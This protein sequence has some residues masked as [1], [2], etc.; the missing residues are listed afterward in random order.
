MITIKNLTVSFPGFS[1]ND[2]DLAIEKGE[3]FILL[4]P[5]GAGKTILLEAIAG[6]VPIQDGHI[7]IAGA[8]VT[9]FPPEKRGVGIVYQDYAL[10]PHLSV[11]DNICYGLHFHEI[12]K[13]ESE[14]RLERLI[15]QLG[16][17]SLTHRSTEH[18]SGGEKQRVALARSLMVAPTVLLLD[19]PLSALD[20]HFRQDLRR[21]LKRLQ[22]ETKI[23][24]FMVTHDLVDVMCLA[25]R[26]A[27]INN[28]SIEQVGTVPDLFQHP[29]TPFVA[30][31]V[32]MKNV[33][34]ATFTANKAC[35]GDVTLDLE[36]A[37][38]QDKK[39][40]AIHP[41]D[42]TL[43]KEP[44]YGPNVFEGRV[45]EISMDGFACE[46]S[47]QVARIRFKTLVAKN[48]L[49][50]LHLSEGSPVYLSIQ[51]SAIHVF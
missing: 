48:T 51:P 30:G 25:D 4:G 24:F 26:V 7:E 15:D 3:F 39:Y 18:L 35:C 14:I 8:D 9:G 22:K 50:D 16:L 21:E 12:D 43:C 29:G 19:E 46:V 32:G 27:I 38:G 45:T 1:L 44:L 13:Q 23:T 36:S 37:P 5:T 42:I 6:L 33:F 41:E 34:P 49:F 40:I 47:S 2:I 17:G 28:G 20:A 10:F 11:L 31:F